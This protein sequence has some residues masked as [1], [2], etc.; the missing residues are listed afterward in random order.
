MQPSGYLTVLNILVAFL[1][2]A[3]GVSLLPLGIP[4]L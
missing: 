2:V 1:G 4:R 3:F